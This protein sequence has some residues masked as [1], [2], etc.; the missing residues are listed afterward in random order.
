MRVSVASDLHLEFAPVTL[1]GGDVLILAGDVWTAAHMEDRKNDGTSRSLRKRYHQFCA[2]ELPKYKEVLMVMGNHEY[3]GS[4]LDR[5]ASIINGFLD[6]WAPNCVLLDNEGVILDGVAFVG[7]TLWAPCGT[8]NPVN[9]MAIWQGMSDF[10]TIHKDMENKMA[11]TPA[12]AAFLH[13]RDVNYIDRT[14]EKFAH[15]PVVMIT[16]HAPSLLCDL[17]P[18]TMS[19]A[20]SSNQHALMKTH[21]HVAVWCHGHTH[22]PVKFI[23]NKTRVISNPRGYF[24]YD[25]IS[26]RFKSDTEDFEIDSGGYIISV[27]SSEDC[28]EIYE[29]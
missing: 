12:D 6:K 23:V 28:I 18:N 22:Q 2:E 5:A 11:F 20:Y 3:Y 9:E 25:A 29:S 14:L 7:S 27:T 15:R 8:E 24:R 13:R 26:S 17:N 21:D 4:S 10:R 16:H 19:D 1:E